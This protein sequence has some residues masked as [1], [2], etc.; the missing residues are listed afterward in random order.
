M[1]FLGDW[2][3]L[4]PIRQSDLPF[5][6][7]WSNDAEVVRYIDGGSPRTLIEAESWL[8][9]TRKDRQVRRFAIE[10]ASGVLIGDMS[11]DQIAW[12]S[13]DAELTVRIGEKEYWGRGLGTDAV[14]VLLDVA[15]GRLR[16]NRVYLRVYR[17]NAR[18]IRSYEKCGFRREG[19]LRRS[20]KDSEPWEE[21]VLM[22]KLRD[23]HVP[24]SQV[25]DAS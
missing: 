17:F 12:R 16:L 3:S 18:A 4:R 25:E 20:A 24:R 8:R 7:S 9:Q 23:E 14:I 21:I 19:V 13:G 10:T 2:V 5:L 22:R 15:F 6:V 11:L 1:V